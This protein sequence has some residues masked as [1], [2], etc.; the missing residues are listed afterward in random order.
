MKVYFGFILAALLWFIMFSPWTAGQINFWYSMCFSAAMLT[1][2]SLYF[3]K[4]DLK[5]IYKFEFRWI[6]IGLLAASA[7]Y[8]IFW[9]G[10]YL[11]RIIFSFASAQIGGIYKIRTQGE[12]LFIGLSLLF[13]IGPAE[14]IFWRGF[15]QYKL[16]KRFGDFKGF[17]IT[18]IIYALIHIWSF[19]FILIMAALICGIFWGWLFKRY[20]NT[21]P[22]I[23]SHAVWDAIIFIVI[24]L[25]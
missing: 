8:L 21:I 13:L 24:P 16:M 19:N 23:I 5:T 10:D 15:A 7:L 6:W 11:S 3:G 12:K 2:L 17:I 4:S 20:K 22:C 9:L 18:T 25:S 1:V 14:E